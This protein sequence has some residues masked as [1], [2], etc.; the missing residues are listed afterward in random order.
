VSDFLRFF[1]VFVRFFQMFTNGTRRVVAGFQSGAGTDAA[2]SSRRACNAPVA[3]LDPA[4][5]AAVVAVALPC[6]PMS[7]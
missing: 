7:R 3:G 1:R 6:A 4:T 2:G 5:V